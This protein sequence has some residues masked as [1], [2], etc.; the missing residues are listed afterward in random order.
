MDRFSMELG[1]KVARVQFAN[2]DDGWLYGNALYSTHDG[3]KSWTQVALPPDFPAW[4]S[5]G[6][7]VVTDGK[8]WAFLTTCRGALVNPHCTVSRIGTS[9]ISSDAWNWQPVSAVT[10]ASLVRSLAMADGRHQW[11][12]PA[13]LAADTIKAPCR[14]L[15]SP[16][17]LDGTS[18]ANLWAVCASSP[19][20]GPVERKAVYRSSD[21]GKRWRKVWDTRGHRHRLPFRHGD[22]NGLAVTSDSTAWIAVWRGPL[23]VSHDGGTSW[24]AALSGPKYMQLGPVEFT[25]ARHGWV[26]SYPGTMLHTTDGGRMWH[27]AT[28]ALPSG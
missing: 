18:P 7:V 2:N 24:K 22:V 14:G 19:G 28:L 12:I 11:R 20:R 8:V 5:F 23:M 3:G 15:I 9:P 13:S 10:V 16:Q 4:T 25:D 26:E 6:P 1:W 27:A 17:Y 21:G